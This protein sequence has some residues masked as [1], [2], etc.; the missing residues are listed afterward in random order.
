MNAIFCVIFVLV[1]QI[2]SN[3]S[4]HQVDCD[5]S[6]IVRLKATGITSFC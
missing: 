2:L 6:L 5:R 4:F 3:R 1:S